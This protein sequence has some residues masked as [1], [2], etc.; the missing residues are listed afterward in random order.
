MTPQHN[1]TR[2]H[3]LHCSTGS[4][5]EIGSHKALVGAEAAS[6]SGVDAAALHGPG[7]G[8]RHAE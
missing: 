7:E 6:G 3:T 5:T 8:E 1:H 4:V 2:S